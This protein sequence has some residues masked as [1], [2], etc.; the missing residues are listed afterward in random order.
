VSAR[1]VKGKD[2]ANKPEPVDIAAEINA[3]ERWRR[4]PAEF[5]ET[6]LFD[7]E[8]RRPFKLLP[9][10]R[11]FMRHA[12]QVGENARLLFP[13]WV[14]A[15]PKKSGKTGFA[16]LLM[17]TTILSFGGRLQKGITRL[18]ILSSRRV[19]SFRRCVASWRHRQT[20]GMLR[21]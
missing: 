6:V 14:H 2:A 17:L 11:G 8:T 18:M 10:E 21:G 7:P 3:P 1:R 12:F 4:D 13:E 16:A 15:A 20:Y 9:A 5:V 19:A